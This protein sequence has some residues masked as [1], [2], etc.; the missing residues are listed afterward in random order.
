MVFKFL[1]RLGKQNGFSEWR[2]WDGLWMVETTPDGWEHWVPFEEHA[3][4][5]PIPP[6]EVRALKDCV[7]VSNALRFHSFSDF[8]TLGFDIPYRKGSLKI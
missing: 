7:V 4:T 5:L 6:R 3:R 1:E 2:W 8:H